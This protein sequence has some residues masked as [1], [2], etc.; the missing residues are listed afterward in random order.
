MTYSVCA[1]APLPHSLSRLLALMCGPRPVTKSGN[2]I[3]RLRL[4]NALHSSVT[5]ETRE[6]ILDARTYRT[7]SLFC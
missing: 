4:S 6:L 3:M 2:R 1:P 7:V 5:A